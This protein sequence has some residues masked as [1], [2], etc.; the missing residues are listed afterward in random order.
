[1]VEVGG[2]IQQM[3]SVGQGEPQEDIITD[4]TYSTLNQ[5]ILL[6]QQGQLAQGMKT[7]FKLFHLRMQNCAPTF[8][9]IM[10]LLLM[11]MQS[12]LLN[13]LTSTI[14]GK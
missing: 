9:K 1:M 7:I 12:F 14:G 10:C 4:I 11:M 8:M 6:A 13:K 2:H 3:S 5:R